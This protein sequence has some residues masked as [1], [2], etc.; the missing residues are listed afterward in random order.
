M[1]PGTCAVAIE[2]DPVDDASS[3]DIVQVWATGGPDTPS[4]EE[5]AAIPEA[6]QPAE[7]AVEAAEPT[8]RRVATAELRAV[9]G[10]TVT[11]AL[12][13]ADAEELSPDEQYRLL[14]LP[15]SARADREFASLL[16]AAD[17]TF[18]M[19]SLPAESPLAGV[20]VGDLDATVVAVRRA[21]GGLDTIPDRERALA[22]GETVYALGRPDVLR[23][24]E[25]RAAGEAPHKA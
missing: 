7:T 4:P 5:V 6:E 14:T 9:T 24:L 2:A 15:V 23:G 16:R 22:G 18:G 12:D 3:G 8:P 19:V 17:E 21:D 25:G 1:G 10:D 11:L 20:T 13:E